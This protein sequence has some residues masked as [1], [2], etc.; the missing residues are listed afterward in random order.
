MI[1]LKTYIMEYS[2]SNI[3]KQKE[4]LRR[5]FREVNFKADKSTIKF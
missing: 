1:G 2:K 5:M 4:E 3:Q